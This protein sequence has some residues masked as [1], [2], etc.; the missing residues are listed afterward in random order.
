VFHVARAHTD[1]DAIIRFRRANTFHMG[2]TF[3]N[4]FYPFI[5]VASGGTLDGV[6]AAAD[7]VLA[8][9][10]D[11]TRIIPGHGPRGG[12]MISRP[13]ATCSPPSAPA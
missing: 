3:M 4:G 6:I 5:D 9:S 12:A 10:D 1:G 2:D 13:I 11:A 7:L 8:G